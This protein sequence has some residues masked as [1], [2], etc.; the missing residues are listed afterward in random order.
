MP[1]PIGPAAPDSGWQTAH[2]EETCRNFKSPDA[3]RLSG[4][5]DSSEVSNV[6]AEFDPKQLFSLHLHGK[7]EMP[8]YGTANLESPVPITA[9]HALFIF[10]GA[11]RNA[12]DYLCALVQMTTDIVGRDQ[13]KLKDYIILAPKYHYMQDLKKSTDHT[14]FEDIV[15]ANELW[16]NG[17]KPYGHWVDGA[18]A[19]PKSHSEYSSYEV[20]DDMLMA[21]N[22][23]TKF[24]KL[25]HIVFVGH[26]A[27][28]QAVQRFALV[29]HVVPADLFHDQTLLQLPSESGVKMLREGL[30]VRFV[31]A[32]PSSYAYLDTNRW[33]YHWDEEKQ[34]WSDM[35]YAEYTAAKG[36]RNWDPQSGRRRD[37]WNKR[38]WGPYSKGYDTLSE[39]R[40][41]ICEDAD[42][43]LW[44]YGLEKAMVQYIRRNPLKAQVRDLYAARDVV[45]MAGTADTC[46]DDML[47]SFCASTCWTAGWWMNRCDRFL[48][49][50]KCPAMLQGPSRY[51]RAR[52][53]MKH[54]EEHFGRPVHALHEIPQVGHQAT[55]MLKSG[56]QTW[57]Y[58]DDVAT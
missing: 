31:I 12:Q 24:P 44:S 6:K 18:A 35:V 21:L 29:T 58:L 36:R 33:A 55:L 13:D 9:K 4:V 53:F 57:L 46:T 42:F 49:D 30:E 3:R 19:D 32:N 11:L 22:D 56:I 20:L 48:M 10:H 5:D 47:G 16:W 14:Q 1:K 37:F 45:Y 54:L 43:N 28:G 51:Q 52:N 41:F 7:A 40:P 26:S 15:D 34:E 23:Q 8:Y 27:G 50:V 17:T 25:K 2:V 39:E 38:T